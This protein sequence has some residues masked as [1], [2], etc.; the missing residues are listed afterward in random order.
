MQHI[1]DFSD[2]KPGRGR[3]PRLPSGLEGRRL[4]DGRWIDEHNTV[5]SHAEATARARKEK[6][7][8]QDL[9]RGKRASRPRAKPKAAQTQRPSQTVQ[10]R[11]K[12]TV[13]RQRSK[14]KGNGACRPCPTFIHDA[15]AAT[16]TTTVATLSAALP[17]SEDDEEEVVTLSAVE[18][19]AEEAVEVEVCGVCH[20]AEPPVDGSL[21][22]QCEAPSGNCSVRSHDVCLARWFAASRERCWCCGERVTAQAKALRMSLRARGLCCFHHDDEDARAEQDLEV[23]LDHS[24]ARPFAPLACPPT[25]GAYLMPGVPA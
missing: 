25:A 1:P 18:V 16:T 23:R 7:H 2:A 3:P 10:P 20:T 21:F 19:A 9:K 4:P 15:P 11:Q 6:Q 14:R 12:P 24:N 22:T 17:E 5:F 13:G 8:K